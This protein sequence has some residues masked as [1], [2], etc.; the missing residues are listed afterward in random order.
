MALALFR[1]GRLRATPCMPPDILPG[2]PWTPSDSPHG[3]CRR[4]SCRASHAHPPYISHAESWIALDI[5]DPTRNPG[6]RPGFPGSHTQTQDP[7]PDPGTRTESS[8][9]PLIPDPARNPGARLSAKSICSTILAYGEP[10]RMQISSPRNAIGWSGFFRL[11]RSR[12]YALG[13]EVQRMAFLMRMK[14]YE[15]L[16]HPRWQALWNVCTAAPSK[17]QSHHVPGSPDC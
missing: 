15:F 11:G 6:S 8:I 10:G 3:A 9:P 4:T 16:R 17:H 2:V 12:G 14:R 13:A 7:A 5:P 1:A